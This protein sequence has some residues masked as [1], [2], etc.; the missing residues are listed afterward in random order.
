M[1]IPATLSLREALVARLKADAGVAALVAGR[2]FD[3]VPE[4]EVFPYVSIRATARAWDTTDDFGKEVSVEINAW[5]RKEGRRE[6][7]LILHALEVSLR[8]MA[9]AVLTDHRLV[10][11]TFEMAD[12]LREEGGQTYFGYAR[13]RAVTEEL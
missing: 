8:T 3:H 4:R 10:N 12:V 2:V 5:S 11:M 6:C 13:F 1:T 7:E 9:P